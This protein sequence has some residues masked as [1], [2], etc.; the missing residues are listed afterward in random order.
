[1]RDMYDPIDMENEQAVFSFQ[2]IDYHNKSV[3]LQ[4]QDLMHYWG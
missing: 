4:M 3:F 1:M 2:G